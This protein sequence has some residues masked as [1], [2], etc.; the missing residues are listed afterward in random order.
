M[1]EVEDACRTTADLTHGFSLTFNGFSAFPPRVLFIRPE[2]SEPLRMLYQTISGQL[3]KIDHFPITA[4]KQ[5]FHAHMTVA[6]RD[7]TPE[8]FEEAWAD[9]HQRHFHETC[10][11]E[12]LH[13][14]KHERGRWK[15]HSSFTFAG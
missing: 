3:A 1:K 13:L 14:L 5:R 11:I 12:E 4:Q 8:A 2:P 9:F 7:L 10:Q 15:A 6:T